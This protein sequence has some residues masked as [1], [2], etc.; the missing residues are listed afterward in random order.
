MTDSP[1]DPP[2]SD[3]RLPSGYRTTPQATSG[4]PTGIPPIIGN[5]AAERFSF[6]GMRGIL[7][8]FMTM[9]LMA[10]GVKAPMSEADATFW[11]H[12]SVMAVYFTPM[13]GAILADR[14]WGKY[15]TIMVL[16][17]VYCAGHAAL[18]I[19][20]T[21]V[22]LFIGLG[23]IALGSGGIKGCV[24]AHVGDQFGAQNSHLLERVYLWFYFS[25]NLGSTLAYLFI[26][27]ILQNYGPHW[28]FGIPG[29][30]MAVA[31]LIFWL[32]RHR[33][34]HIPAR[35][36]QF[37]S[38]TFS[39]ENLAAVGRMAV[40]FIFVALF[41]CLFDQSSSRWVLQAG[42]LDQTLFGITVTPDQMQTANPIMVMA[43]L[44][45]CG[46]VI[47]PAISRFF[48]LTPLRKIGIGF[49]LAVISF[50][51]PAWLESRIDAGATP[52]IAWQVVAYFFLTMAEVMISPTLLEFSYT[53][54][55]KSGKSLMLGVNLA[56][57]AL[58]NLFTAIVNLVGADS[59]TGPSYYLFFAGLMLLAALVFIPFA[60]QFRERLVLQDG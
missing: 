6:Y 58:G 18:A 49:F 2:K 53:Q 47:Y 57:V 5:E 13:L 56:S 38:E 14:W 35:G 33:Y 1:Y 20:S 10:N 34:A 28:A 17:M 37:W 31:T 11:F 42:K 30:A 7:M 15:K 3:L 48:P 16:S 32:G 27:K 51:I 9:H 41:W 36:P 60:R 26:P 8:T 59:L 22:G 54:A 23:L 44:P 40:L 19:D 25:I 45:L 43:F 4:M 29:I 50:L 55:A 24:S 12:I 52:T 39:K 21:R 46:F